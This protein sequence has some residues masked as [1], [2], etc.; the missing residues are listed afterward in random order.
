MGSYESIFIDNDGNVSVDGVT[1]WNRDLVYLPFDLQKKEPTK[2]F[3]RENIDRA[4][5]KP[6]KFGDSEQILA[7][8]AYQVFT[9]QKELGTFNFSILNLSR[10]VFESCTGNSESIERPTIISIIFSREIESISSVPT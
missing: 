6:L 5:N 9:I 10:P 7:L 3:V 4:F 1:Y 8:K 2:F